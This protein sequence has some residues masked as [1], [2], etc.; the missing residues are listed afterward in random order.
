[1]SFFKMGRK[2]KD[3]TNQH[4]MESLT[5]IN[6]RL[7][8]QEQAVEEE[9]RRRPLEASYVPPFNPTRG[10]Y[11]TGDITSV[12][13]IHMHPNLRRSRDESA[14]FSSRG[15]LQE[16][17]EQLKEMHTQSNERLDRTEKILEENMVMMKQILSEL[18]NQTPDS[19]APEVHEYEEID[20]YDT[21]RED[22]LISEY[23]HSRVLFSSI[24]D[25]K[26]NLTMGDITHRLLSQEVIHDDEEQSIQAEKTHIRKIRRLVSSLATKRPEKI[27]RFLEVLKSD[28][29]S[30]Y[31]RLQK[32]LEK[33]KKQPNT[34]I[35]TGCFIAKHVDIR[36][37]ADTM[38]GNLSLDNGMYKYFSNGSISE[39]EKWREMESLTSF[40]EINVR[41]R[42]VQALRIE[43]PQV[44]AMVAFTRDTGSLA[45]RCPNKQSRPSRRQS[46]TTIKKKP[47]MQLGNM[48]KS[49]YFFGDDDDDQHDDMGHDDD[50]AVT[51]I[52]STTIHQFNQEHQDDSSSHVNQADNT[53]YYPQKRRHGRK[54]NIMQDSIT[55]T[56]PE[57]VNPTANGNWLNKMIAVLLLLIACMLFY[58]TITNTDVPNILLKLKMNLLHFMNLDKGN[59]TVV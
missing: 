2:K 24:N 58:N 9:R 27:E 7:E 44:A 52:T 33:E 11:S 17:F 53:K 13:N 46:K 47:G 34:K 12:E 49:H 31:Q 6:R 10:S 15:S 32:K 59:K 43:Y 45:C 54:R 41:N 50:D 19:P 5:N 35:C 57:A 37:I 4:I 20:F 56:T 23:P 40:Q 48:I 38:L 1:M 22:D 36:N 3:N 14:Y 21:M 25:L 26:S 29:F 16:E 8:R 39:K 51:S 42:F 28:H 55:S 18:K 30:M